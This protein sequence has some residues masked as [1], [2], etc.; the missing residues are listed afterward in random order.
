[1][2]TSYNKELEFITRNYAIVYGLIGVTEVS[3]GT[4]I[5]EE[6]ISFR[7]YTPIFPQVFLNLDIRP[8]GHRK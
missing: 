5:M 7:K 2:K 1:M 8:F 4:V 6:E 3:S